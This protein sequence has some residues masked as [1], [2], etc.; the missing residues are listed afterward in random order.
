MNVVEP[1]VH[2]VERDFER[3]ALAKW[4]AAT[5]TATNNEV[6][7]IDSVV[8]R[9]VDESAED[10]F[11]VL[12]VPEMNWLEKLWLRLKSS[13]RWLRWVLI[14]PPV[15][16]GLW[17]A[18]KALRARFKGRDRLTYTRDDENRLKA[19]KARI[20]AHAEAAREEVNRKADNLLDAIREKLG[21]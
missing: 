16:A 1:Y 8:F 4:H 12:E 13:W 9:F 17:R 7:Y 6:V 21:E 19:E 5:W 2:I 3:A 20:K 11:L 15:L 18:Y 10:A 14:A